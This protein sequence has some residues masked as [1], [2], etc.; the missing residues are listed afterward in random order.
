MPRTRGDR[1]GSSGWDLRLCV[2]GDS[3]VQGVGDPSGAGWVTPVVEAAGGCVTAY[4]LGVRGDTS[5]DV[6]RRWYDEAR[7]RLKDGDRYGVLFSFGVNDTHVHG[8]RTRVPHERSL[9]VLAA[10]LDEAQ[11]AGWPAIVAGPVPPADGAHRGRVRRLSDDMAWVCTDRVVPFVDLA[12]PLGTDQ[13]WLSEL[14]AGG[15]THP[16]ATGYWK[17]AN[18]IRP[19]F[20][21]WVATLAEL[22]L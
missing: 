6:Q 7:C 8:G 5:L 20:L 13:D 16:G 11:T 2:F 17:L 22:D 15:G 3:Y 21:V 18:L 4:R 19:A 9:T 1:V 10:M 14:A 12:T